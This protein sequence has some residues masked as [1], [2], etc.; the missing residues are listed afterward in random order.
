MRQMMVGTRQGRGFRRRFGCSLLGVFLQV[1]CRFMS[2]APLAT[3]WDGH[4]KAE[5]EGG[6]RLP[7]VLEQRLCAS[8]VL[9]RGLSEA[10][11]SSSGRL[12]WSLLRPS[13]PRYVKWSLF[14][15]RQ[16]YPRLNDVD[17]LAKDP[18]SACF[19]CSCPGI[20]PSHEAIKQTNPDLQNIA[21]RLIDIYM[22]S[23]EAWSPRLLFRRPFP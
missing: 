3:G 5:A 21:P 4:R 20:C 9:S 10:R 6:F 2:A 8:N 17:D 15:S 18:A 7:V 11:M 12:R 23:Q 1:C 16:D 19:P 22:Y 14:A 13:S